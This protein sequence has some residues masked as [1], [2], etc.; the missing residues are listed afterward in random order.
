VLQ[1]LQEPTKRGGRLCGDAL[2]TCLTAT[3]ATLWRDTSSALA[4]QSGAW[5]LAR[6]VLSS[7]PTAVHVW[8][9]MMRV[10]TAWPHTRSA[11]DRVQ[12]QQQDAR[13]AA[14]LEGVP[15]CFTLQRRRQHLR[16]EAAQSASC[17]DMPWRRRFV[18]QTSWRNGSCLR[19]AKLARAEHSACQTRHTR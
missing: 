1:G 2:N 12:Q 14:S 17:A 8:P 19:P 10:E 11:A 6:L 4:I 3:A 7:S 9:N 13:P 16:F 18:G 5:L 15:R